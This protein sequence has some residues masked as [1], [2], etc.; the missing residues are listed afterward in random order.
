MEMSDSELRNEMLCGLKFCS[1]FNKIALETVKLMKEAY[2]G[3]CFGE[4]TIFRL[5][6]DFKIGRLSVELS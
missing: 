5:H 4:S 1:L 6:G 2:K 3:K